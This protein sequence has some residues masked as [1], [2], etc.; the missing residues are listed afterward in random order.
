MGSYL[1]LSN[2]EL[3]LLVLAGDEEARAEARRRLAPLVIR[4]GRDDN[5]HEGRGEQ[6]GRAPPGTC[7]RPTRHPG[8][9]ARPGA[10]VTK[11]R[12]SPRPSV[13][14]PIWSTPRVAH[15]RDP[16]PSHPD[17]CRHRVVVLGY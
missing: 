16:G 15:R 4:L 12:S 5:P 2:E 14:D 7:R 10:E 3:A 6:G 13:I 1:D 17:T 11:T 8:V 9:H